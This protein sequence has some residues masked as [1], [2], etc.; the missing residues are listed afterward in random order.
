MTSC[1]VLWVNFDEFFMI[2]FYVHLF[3]LY[4]LYLGQCMTFLLL[5][6]V[7][8]ECWNP[9]AASGGGQLH[10]AGEESKASMAGM[11]C[12]EEY[13]ERNMDV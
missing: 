5:F 9:G 1:V 11:D 12:Q 10:Q 8:K 3:F 2:H 13:R 7:Q 6:S 4:I